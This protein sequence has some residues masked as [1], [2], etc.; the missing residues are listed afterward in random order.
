[1]PTTSTTSS[2]R[3]A[4]PRTTTTVRTRTACLA[5]AEANHYAAV[6]AN[7]RWFDE[8][9]QQLSS[10]PVLRARQFEALRIEESWALKEM[11]VQ[12]AIDRS[13]CYLE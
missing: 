12:Y 6:S 7:A 3:P 13:N 2:T 11:D 9:M 10:D 8:Q 1:V 5:L 4:A